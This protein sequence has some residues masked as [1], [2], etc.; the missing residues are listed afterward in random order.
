[1]AHRALDTNDVL[2]REHRLDGVDG[3]VHLLRFQKLPLGFRIGIAHAE[4]HEEAVQLGLRQRISALMLD[5]ILSRQ[6]DE[7]LRERIGARI[8]ANLRFVHRF[9]HRGLCLGRCAVDLVR[10]EDVRKDEAP[11]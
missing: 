9:E 1:M 2:R 4:A 3:T 10:E 6:D 11:A 7:R 8:D 5:W